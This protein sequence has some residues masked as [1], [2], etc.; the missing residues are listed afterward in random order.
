MRLLLI[1]SISVLS[2][3]AI[4]QGKVF[5]KS[6]HP[7]DVVCAFTQD[8]YNHSFLVEGGNIQVNSNDC[9]QNRYY[10]TTIEDGDN[11]QFDAVCNDTPA[12][13]DYLW[14]NKGEGV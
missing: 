1:I 5:C 8:D 4:T 3:C 10:I 14:I 6:F 12:V 9:K 11:S 2:G 13:T 7:P